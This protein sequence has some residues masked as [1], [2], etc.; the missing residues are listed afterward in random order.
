MVEEGIGWVETRT[1]GVGWVD[2]G[3]EA[4]IRLN[5]FG[6]STSCFISFTVLNVFFL[7]FLFRVS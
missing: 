4:C 6:V 5:R 3:S 1:F 2:C 7:G